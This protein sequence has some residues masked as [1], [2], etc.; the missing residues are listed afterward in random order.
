MT[1]S[2]CLGGLACPRC[3]NDS[4]FTIEVRTLAHVTDDGA[5]TFGDMHWD[6]NSFV[7]CL[8]C[9]HQ[10]TLA[11]FQAADAPTSTTNEEE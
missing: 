8:E 9:H 3:G 7:E 11:A 1:N 10:A 5:E 6:A 2:N 4:R